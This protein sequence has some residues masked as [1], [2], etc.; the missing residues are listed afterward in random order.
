MKLKILIIIMLVI[1][2]ITGC[3]LSIPIYKFNLYSSSF[4]YINE[5]K[6]KKYLKQHEFFSNIQDEEYRFKVG[7]CYANK[8][9][10][11]EI[12]NE[13]NDVLTF[14]KD[15]CFN[16]KSV[17][18]CAIL[19]DIS[20]N[21]YYNKPTVFRVIK[22]LE[23]EE[24]LLHSCYNQTILQSAEQNTSL[25]RPKHINTIL[26]LIKKDNLLKKLHTSKIYTLYKKIEKH[27]KNI[28]IYDFKPKNRISTEYPDIE[29]KTNN[30]KI[31]EI[32]ITSSMLY[33]TNCLYSI[34][35]NVFENYEV[36]KEIKKDKNTSI[37]L[38][39]TYI[40]NKYI[41]NTSF[42]PA[43]INSL[44]QTLLKDISFSHKE[45]QLNLM[46]MRSP[47]YFYTIKIK[48]VK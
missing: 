8:Q 30:N 48:S 27:N 4:Q 18:N 16:E 5:E 44:A 46:Q 12:S 42:I 20:A 29:I 47:S 17:I 43:E 26:K 36:I 10:H 38:N 11:N 7:M 22:T 45:K 9:L 31:L 39:K 41:I 15:K 32:T 34:V 6:L 21:I 13:C 1:V 24:Q 37:I 14:S 35:S 2:F 19:R 3:Q 25:T 28:I 33:Q 23:K 40:G